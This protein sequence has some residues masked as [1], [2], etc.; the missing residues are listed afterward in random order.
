M[1]L[2]ARFDRRA[3]RPPAA[4]TPEAE[5]A[6]FT[7]DPETWQALMR[8]CRDPAPEALPAALLQPANG[9]EHDPDAALRAWADAL[10][11]QLDGGTAL[12]ALPGGWPKLA[13]RLRVKWQ[14]LRADQRDAL[15]TV[16]DAGWLRSEPQ[17]LHHLAAHWWPRRPTLLL[18]EAAQAPQL[19]PVQRA[20]G[21]RLAQAAQSQTVRPVRWLWLGASPAGQAATSPPPWTQVWTLGGG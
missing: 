7:R 8:W 19:W 21:L 5:A 12:D 10:A 18:A 15:P 20:L 17:A 11:R 2:A 3:L 4:A 9:G 6:Q 14:D 1:S 13:L 16:W